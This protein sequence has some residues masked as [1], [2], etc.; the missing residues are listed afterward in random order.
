M[1][2]AL[3]FEGSA[4]PP[5]SRRPAKGVQFEAPPQPQAPMQPGRLAAQ[6]S[7]P[8]GADPADTQPGAGHA[9]RRRRN[10]AAR[11]Q[12]ATFYFLCGL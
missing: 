5:R 8:G 9:R 4:Q 6:R 7:Q 10:P 12:G 11:P 1:Y 2:V 3:P